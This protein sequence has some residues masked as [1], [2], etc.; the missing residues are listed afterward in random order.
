MQK[1]ELKPAER[2]AYTAQEVA[3]LTGAS[4]LSVERAIDSGTLPHIRLG[5]RDLVPAS[6]VRKLVDGAA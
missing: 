3:T 6:E 5:Q 1:L 2:L 4:V